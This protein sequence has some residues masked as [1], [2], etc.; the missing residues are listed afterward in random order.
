MKRPILPIALLLGAPC[1]FFLAFFL[2]PMFVVALASLT[3]A[4]GGVS[5]ANYERIL[6]DRYH[7]DV[8]I[9][10]FKLAFLTTLLC[11]LLGYP[12]A[13]YLVRNVSSRMLRRVF[14]IL[15]ILP[16]FTSNIVRSFGW[17]VL[18][19]RRGLLNDS[20]LTS[21]LIDTPIRLLGTE[22][23]ILIGLVYVHLPFIVLTVG[24]AVG[25]VD[26][27]LENAARDLG[28]GRAATFWTVTFPLCLPG[29][30]AGA[31]M[32]FT[33]SVSAYV[34]PALLGGGRITMFSMLIFQQYSSVFD[35][36]YGGALSC[37]LLVLTLLMVAA[38]NRVGAI[39]RA[40]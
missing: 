11:S 2:A 5:V 37:T 36:H 28:A 33:L 25:K 29:L 34:T 14:V 38:A 17:I 35:F 24:N 21:G 30:L 22:T 9:L 31:I 3:G 19:G 6:L 7:W 18:L 8:L 40:A 32:V 4:N 20:L 27:S 13:Y 15:L 10:T 39:R 1:A 23:G 16:L 26:R 12:L